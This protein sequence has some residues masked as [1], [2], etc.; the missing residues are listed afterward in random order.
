MPIDRRVFPLGTPGGGWGLSRGKSF[1]ADD[2]EGG[3]FPCR[4]F[5]RHYSV[6][7]NPRIV[8]ISR[9]KKI[10]ISSC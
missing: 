10:M 4:S 3:A 2:T 1:P 6:I 7:T 8:E 9:N 5:P